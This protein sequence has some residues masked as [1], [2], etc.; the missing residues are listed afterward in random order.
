MNKENLLNLSLFILRVA[1]GV[2]FFVHGGQKLFGMFDGIGLEGTTK[3]VEGFGLAKPYPI[4][5]AWA[6]VEFA[7]G[8]FLLL[9]IVVRWAAFF[10][11]A[12]VIAYLWKT[13]FIHGSFLTG[14][15]IEYNILIVISCMQLVLV[16]GGSW[17]IW[18]V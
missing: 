16:G 2:I 1:V 15:D 17:A 12:T 13:D 3:L 6:S 7:G 14:G 4:A 9:G 8:I 5:I 18:D 10:I 11:L